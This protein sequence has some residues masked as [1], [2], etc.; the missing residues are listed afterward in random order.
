M[1]GL[2]EWITVID[3]RARETR[4]RQT[5]MDTTLFRMPGPHGIIPLS[6]VLAIKQ[7]S[8]VQ[9]NWFLIT[10]VAGSTPLILGLHVHM[11]QSRGS[12]ASA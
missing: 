3:W 10:K 5:I 1:T 4:E 8:Y 9:N 6:V 2:Y 11:L 7:L 12:V